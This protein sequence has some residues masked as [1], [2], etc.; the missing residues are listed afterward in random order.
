[1]RSFRRHAR[2][3]IAVGAVAAGGCGDHD[4]DSQSQTREEAE[5]LIIE[6]SP[7]ILQSW[8]SM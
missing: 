1:M 7:L 4:P 8:R 3:L 2:V 6:S 5:R